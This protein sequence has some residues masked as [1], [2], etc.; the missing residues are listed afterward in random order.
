MVTSI[1]LMLSNSEIESLSSKMCLDGV[2]EPSI[3]YFASLAWAVVCEP[4][5][6]FAG[7][8]VSTFGAARS[9]E[10]EIH[11]TS[12][13]DYAKLFAEAGSDW[14]ELQKFGR[15]EKTLSDARERWT[16]RLTTAGVKKAI[17]EMSNLNGWFIAEHSQH[18]PK[19]LD[20]LGNH[21]PRGL[22]GIGNPEPCTTRMISIV[23]SR[24]ASSYGEFATAELLGPLVM[25]GYS[26]VSGGAYGIDAS[27][28]R[29]TV[30]MEGSTIA[31]MAGGL[32]RLY[33]S[34]NRDL[35]KAITEQGAVVSEMPPGSE[36]TKWRFLQRN[37]LIAALGQGTIVVEA[38]ARSGAVSTA[39]RAIELERPLGAVPGPIDSPGSDGCHQLIRDN[40]AQ[41]ITCSEDILEMLGANTIDSKIEAAGLGALELR[42]LDVIGF[43]VA[44]IARIC[45]EGGLTRSEAE[46]GIAGLSLLGVIEQDSLGWRR[47]P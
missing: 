3:D 35:F 6:A 47:M 26:V 28:H 21:A 16:P 39:N 30:A 44:D 25:R 32:D 33:P 7:Q 24:V 18:W 45:S 14:L 38:N 8:L 10:L 20:D 2:N 12:A 46:I 13:K 23:G 1:D 29:A 4:G 41:L 9:L 11:R 5:D 36:P 40:K 17:E 15:F 22:W 19:S 27:A 37:R 42:V 31:V 43:S 34:G